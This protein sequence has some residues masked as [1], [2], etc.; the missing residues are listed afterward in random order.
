MWEGWLTTISVDFRALNVLQKGFDTVCRSIQNGGNGNAQ[1]HQRR[2]ASA[3]LLLVLFLI[4]Q[5]VDSSLYNR[6]GRLILDANDI[7]QMVVCRS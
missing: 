5:S 2:R 3:V 6:S 7:E 1:N 4:Y